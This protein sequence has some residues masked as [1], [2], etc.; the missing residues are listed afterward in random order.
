[1]YPE[2]TLAGVTVAPYLVAR[3]AFVGVGLAL[4]VRLNRGL[5]IPP[6]DTVAAFALG[7]PA[8]LLGAHL[9]SVLERGGYGPRDAGVLY[10]WRDH[11]AIFGALLGGVLAGAAYTSW[12]GLSLRRLLDGGAPVMALGEGMTRI[13]CFLAG[14]CHGRPTQSWLGVRFP[15]ESPVF[16]TQLEHAW[17]G[18]P[19]AAWSVPVHPTQLYAAAFGFG[20]CA[21]LIL[22]LPR[23]RYDGQ[24]FCAFLFAYGIWRFVLFYL[25]ADPGPV[26][27]AGLYTS[28]LAALAAIAAAALLERRW[29]GAAA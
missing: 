20:L 24:A 18:D 21:L 28:Q 29:T 27:I 22:L 13:G 1:M 11:S 12:R 19:T 17:L 9:L 4:A 2:L 10:F 5:G 23:R 26:V 16:R 14:C 3:Y 7:L 25:R 8:A 15:R 6:R